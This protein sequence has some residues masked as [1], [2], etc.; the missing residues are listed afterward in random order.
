MASSPV[1]RTSQLTLYTTVGS[2][3]NGAVMKL[4]AIPPALSMTT[5]SHGSDIAWPRTIAPEELDVLDGRIVSRPP[6]RSMYL[7]DRVVVGI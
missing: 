6:G 1:V 2:I 4:A 5:P 3:R 7:D